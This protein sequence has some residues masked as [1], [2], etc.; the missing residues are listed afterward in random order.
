MIGWVVAVFAYPK[1]HEYGQMAIGSARLQ[2]WC[3]QN[4]DFRT[5]GRERIN[6][7]VTGESLY[8]YTAEDGG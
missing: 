7:S 8:T 1:V 2:E 3:I 6:S 5:S 4:W